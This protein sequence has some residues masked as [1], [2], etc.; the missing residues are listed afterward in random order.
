MKYVRIKG[1]R[2]DLELEYDATS[3]FSEIAGS[4]VDAPIPPKR[5]QHPPLILENNPPV[6]TP[7]L[8]N[9][10]HEMNPTP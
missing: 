9:L 6:N 8:N 5:I 10:Q 4:S 2:Q 7:I 1:P 3:H